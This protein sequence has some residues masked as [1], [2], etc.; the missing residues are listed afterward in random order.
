MLLLLRMLEL[1]YIWMDNL[2]NLSGIKLV[3][4]FQLNKFSGQINKHLLTQLKIYP[5][6]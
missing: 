1:K 4:K 2:I 5:L 3:N 6:N